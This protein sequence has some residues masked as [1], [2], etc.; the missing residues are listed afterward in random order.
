MVDELVDEHDGS[1]ARSPGL[2]PAAATTDFAAPEVHTSTPSSCIVGSSTTELM[3]T[4]ARRISLEQRTDFSQQKGPSGKSYRRD[5]ASPQTRTIR[6][7]QSPNLRVTSHPH[8]IHT[9]TLSHESNAS[10]ASSTGHRRSALEPVDTAVSN[11]DHGLGSVLL[12][13]AGNSPWSMTSPESKR[14]SDQASRGGSPMVAP[15]RNPTPI[16]GSRMER[17]MSE[18]N[19]KGMNVH[20]KPFK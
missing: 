17:T 1:F 19:R 8:S 16:D 6:Q 3:S 15:R 13:G 14:L 7:A 11:D 9:R 5:S 18:G 20:A 4:A 12:F 2:A 10:I